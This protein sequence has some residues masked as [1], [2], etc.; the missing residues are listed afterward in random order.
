[1][2][3]NDVISFSDGTSIQSKIKNIS[4]NAHKSWALGVGINEPLGNL[5]IYGGDNI[6]QT[7]IVIGKGDNTNTSMIMKYLDNDKLII[8]PHDTSTE[9]NT[10][11]NIT[12]SGTNG[13]VGIGITNPSSKLYVNGAI[14]SASTIKATDFVILDADGNESKKL[15][16]LE[17]NLSKIEIDGGMSA[18]VSSDKFKVVDSVNTERLSVDTDGNLSVLGN[19]N[20][21]G[22]L[23]LHN[24]TEFIS[25]PR[26]VETISTQ[27]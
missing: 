22:Q 13:N 7:N 23:L 19:I 16:D 8:M 24:G 15:S 21:E 26:V 6:G 27:Y 1:M 14:K 3:K 20:F 25:N 11:K 10:D 18:E 2:F 17:N 12:L 5:H 4:N 9:I